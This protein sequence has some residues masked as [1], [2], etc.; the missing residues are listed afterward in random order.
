MLEI[1]NLAS[2]QSVL[3]KNLNIPSQTSIGQVWQDLPSKKNQL[4]SLKILTWLPPKHSIKLLQVIIDFRTPQ[5]TLSTGKY[6]KFV[7]D[8]KGKVLQ[9]LELTDYHD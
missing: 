8:A 5:L 9:E 4:N 6:E 1:S 7:D 2:S 3:N